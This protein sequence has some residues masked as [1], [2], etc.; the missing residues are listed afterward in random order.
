MITAMRRGDQPAAE[1]ALT[2]YLASVPLEVLPG[3]TAQLGFVALALRE[4]AL[5]LAQAAVE[6]PA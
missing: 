6:D 3:A 2:K 1:L 5:K 4:L